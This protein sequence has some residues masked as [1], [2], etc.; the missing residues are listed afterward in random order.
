VRD[1]YSWALQRPCGTDTVAATRANASRA[2]YNMTA[3]STL[4]DNSALLS[5]VMDWTPHVSS[6]PSSDDDGGMSLPLAPFLMTPGV[7]D[8]LSSVM[9][10]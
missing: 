8:L 9:P 1:V 3:P 5:S 6:F 2:T 4:P 7:M 10:S